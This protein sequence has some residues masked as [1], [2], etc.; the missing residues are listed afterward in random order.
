MENG[1]VGLFDTKEGFTAK[2]AKYKAEA[3]TRYIKNSKSLFG[4]VVILDNNEWMYNDQ[5][6]CNYNSR[7][8]SDW[9]PVILD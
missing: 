8:L 4:G 9:R 6:E 3:L 1:K 5:D 7:N 2:E